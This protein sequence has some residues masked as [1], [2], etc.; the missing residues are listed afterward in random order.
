MRKRLTARKSFMIDI[1]CGSYR[2]NI[3]IIVIHCCKDEYYYAHG[4][5]LP[6]SV[7]RYDINKLLIINYK[8]RKKK[9]ANGFTGCIITIYDVL[10]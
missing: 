8:I 5:C 4:C 2:N 7:F 6:L 1:S 10:T 3:I 9:Y